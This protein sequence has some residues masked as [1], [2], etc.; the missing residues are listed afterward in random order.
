MEAQQVEKI[1]TGANWQYEPKWDGFRCLAF[2]HGDKVVLQSKGARPLGRYFPEI[3]EALR[4]LPLGAFVL[5]G[6]LIVQI[7]GILSFGELQMR[8]HPAESRVR[9]LAAAHPARLAI[10]DL[11]AD[12]KLRDWTPRPLAERRAALEKLLGQVDLGDRLLLS[13]AVRNRAQAERWLSGAGADLDGVIAKRLDSDY[14]SGKRDGMVKVKNIRTVE[15]VVGGFRYG[16]SS[17]F[18]GSLLLGLYDE[19]G[20]L[21]HVGFTSALAADEKPK[22]TRRLEKLIQTPGFT[23]D[24]PGGLSRWSTRRSGDWRPLA[25]KLVVEVT[26]DHVTEGRFRH[27]TNLVRWRSDKPPKDCLLAQI[28]PLT[29]ASILPSCTR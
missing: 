4:A 22:L 20:L 11:L 13:P 16:E 17:K 19:N 3:V 7:G 26:Y 21:H 6:E 1:P 5:D 28:V 27:G 24:A 15:C 2:R 10:F 8:L 12:T 25:P 23:G 14:R 9:K 18:V 29:Q